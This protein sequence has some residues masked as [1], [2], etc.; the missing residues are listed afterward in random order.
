MVPLGASVVSCCSLVSSMSSPSAS[1]QPCTCVSVSS[2]RKSSCSASAPPDL[3]QA[4]ERQKTLADTPRIVG[5]C[6]DVE[7]SFDFWESYVENSRILD[8]NPFT[9]R[10]ELAEGAHFV[11]GGDAVDQGNGDLAFLRDLMQLQAKYP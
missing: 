6:T 5:Y 9:Q 7:G 10:L 11:F 8:R 4:A 1:H 2:A 3:T